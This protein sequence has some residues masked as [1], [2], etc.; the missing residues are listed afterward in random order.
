MNYKPIY[1]ID[2]APQI[3]SVSEVML[4][5]GDSKPSIL[6]MIHNGTITATRPGVRG[7][8]RVVRDSVKAAYHLGEHAT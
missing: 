7:K 8:W 4:H 6:K 3:M 1:N 2:R 5:T